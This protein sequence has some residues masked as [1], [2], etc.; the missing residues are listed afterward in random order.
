MAAALLGACSDGA[1]SPNDP[2]GEASSAPAAAVPNV[3]ARFYDQGLSWKGCG[4][5]F[6]CSRLTVPVRTTR[7]TC[8]ILPVCAKANTAAKRKHAA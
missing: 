1:T 4:G 5:D 3:L 8:G 2:A 7:K 6:Q